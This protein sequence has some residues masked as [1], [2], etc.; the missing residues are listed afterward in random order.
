[1]SSVRDSD[2]P[3]TYGLV[4]VRRERRDLPRSL[5]DRVAASAVRHHFEESSIPFQCECGDAACRELALLTLEEYDRVRVEHQ[6]LLAP[7]HS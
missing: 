5:N 1:M 3:G 6:P 2:R 7:A 4:D